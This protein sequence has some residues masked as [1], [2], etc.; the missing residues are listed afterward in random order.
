MRGAVSAKRRVQGSCVIA[1]DSAD[2]LDLEA[3]QCG[4]QAGQ[5]VIT[6]CLVSA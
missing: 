4:E 1:S 3:D 6:G 2:A 5:S